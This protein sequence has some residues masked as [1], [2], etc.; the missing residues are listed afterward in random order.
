MRIKYFSFLFVLMFFTLGSNIFANVFAHNVR[1]TQPESTS[2]FDGNFT[3]GT[4]AAIRFTLSDVADEVIVSIYDENSTIIR[5]ITESNFSSGDTLV[6]W[7]GKNDTGDDVSSGDYKV[8][9]K[10]SSAGYS[11]YTVLQDIEVGIYT[12]GVTSVKT[13]NVKNFGFVFSASGGGYAAGVTRHTNDLAQWGDEKGNATLSVTYTD[14][15]STVGSDNLRYSTEADDDGYIYVA[16]RSGTVPAIYRYQADELVISMIDSGGYNGSP[17]GIA[18]NGTGTD[19]YIAVSNAGGEVYGFN[20]G[21]NDTWFQDKE[22]LL[23]DSTTIFWDMTYGRD[24]ML[25]ATYYAA[26]TSFLPG[27]AAFNMNNYSGTAFT[28]QDAAWTVEGPD[29]ATGNTI[30]Y[31]FADDA[32]NDKIYFTLARRPNVAGVQGIYAVKNLTTTPE[33]ELVYLDPEDN[34]TQFRADVT[35]DAAGNVIIFENSN[36]FTTLIS[37]PDGENEYEYMNDFDVIKVFAAE[38]IADVKVDADNDNVPDRSGETV[39]VAGVVTSVNFVASA[40]R[41]SYYIQDESGA[42]NIT[43]GDEEGGGTVYNIGDRLQVTGEIGQY[44]GTTQLNIADLATDVTLLGNVD[45]IVPLE[46][47]IFDLLENAEIY[48]GSLVKI[49]AAA[50]T[51]SSNDWPAA[52]S[53]ANMTITDGSG[54]LVL[55]IDKD[56]DIDGQTEPDY[57]ISIVGVVT[58]YSSSAPYNDGYQIS[59]NFYTDI[60]GNVPAPPSPYFYA[61]ET[62][63]STFDDKTI[64]INSH[65]ETFTFAWEDAVDLNGDDLIYQLIVITPTSEMF[66][67]TGGN[68]LQ[69]PSI[70]L[71]GLEVINALGDASQTVQLTMRTKGN[72]GDL[73]VSVDT[74][75]TTFDIVVGVDEE[76]LIPKDFYVDQNYPN[77]FNPA[78]TIRF[79]L[80]E[81]AD[82]NLI[83]YDILGR[84]V[85]TL[86]NSRP[87]NAG[88]H[89]IIF[90]ASALASGTYVYRLSAGNK[91]EI[92]KMLLLK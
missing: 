88:I 89:S 46:I 73:V 1:V 45:P 39:I 31:H 17:Q 18:I 29:T 87:M 86:I 37:P 47:A 8:S 5:T 79:G 64:S 16:R 81:A 28:L 75:T 38:P 72:E 48:E 21:E 42:I 3:D 90:N 11:E 67:P 13:Q 83:I 63:K 56:T 49:M 24:N 92:K 57:P 2:P 74:I 14:S 66:L 6:V 82:V 77:P 35:T 41:F 61:T 91:V 36:E 33:R 32:A 23:I 78:T 34:M 65:D 54:E 10:T 53:D 58:Q 9:I 60:V 26:D 44:M 12:R 71:T 27:V 7:D 20:I 84:E 19:K 68:I 55:R 43:K 52:D 70:T 62:T 4:H 15:I 76:D 80:P 40:D 25:Y 69:E 22:P 85:A 59:P 50:K 30:T 51:E